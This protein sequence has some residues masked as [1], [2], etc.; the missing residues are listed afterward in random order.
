MRTAII[1]G[2][3]IIALSIKE[4]PPLDMRVT[5]LLLVVMAFIVDA[6]EW[7]EKKG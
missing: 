6:V 5:I 2:A 7:N 3:C 4:N 1:V